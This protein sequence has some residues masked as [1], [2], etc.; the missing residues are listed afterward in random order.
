MRVAARLQ[1]ATGNPISVKDSTMAKSIAGSAT[2]SLALT[3]NINF[4]HLV[5]RINYLVEITDQKL[6]Q[7]LEFRPA[8]DHW[9]S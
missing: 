8:A 9:L 7:T 5:P 1:A 2:A 4:R 3:Q 6:D